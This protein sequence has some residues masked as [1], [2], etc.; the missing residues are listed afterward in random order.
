MAKSKKGA[1]VH[2]D[3]A[4]LEKIREYQ[5]FVRK[6]HPEMPVPTKGQIV[7]SGVLY[8]HKNSLGAWA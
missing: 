1:T 3:D 6:N 2:L 5:E 4:T 8:W 7:R